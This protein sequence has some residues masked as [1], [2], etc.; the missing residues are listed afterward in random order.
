MKSPA[1][2]SSRLR[3]PGLA[4]VFV[5]VF[6]AGCGASESDL[7]NDLT[8]LTKELRGKIAPLPAVKPY[9]P[10]PY[11]T[12]NRADPFSVEKSALAIKSATASSTP[13][14]DARRVRE[15]LEAYP[16]EVLRYSGT[17]RQNGAV[18]ALI[19]VDNNLHTVRLG[20]RLGQNH[21]RIVKILDDRLDLIELVENS[22]GEWT[23]RSASLMLPGQ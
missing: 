9:T 2:T 3:M 13:A 15:P 23:E 7:S 19:T 8:R 16:L 10:H 4:G 20:G 22:N 5:L 18:H 12:D 17:I 6:L 11:S 14:P 1:M 21:G